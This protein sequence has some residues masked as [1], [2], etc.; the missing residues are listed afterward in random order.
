MKL[1]VWARRQSR[2]A[3]V[4]AVYQWQ[5]SDSEASS[6]EADFVDSGSLEK[7]DLEFF[8]ELL[9]GV[10]SQQ[11]ELD[12]LIEPLLDRKL[13]ALDQI[14]LA[15][16]RLGTLELKNRID[17]PY[18]VVIDQYVDLAKTFGAEEGHKY[19]NG[20]LDKLAGILRPLETT[21]ERV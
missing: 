1:N 21:S 4:Q 16:L 10:I 2:R 5:M 9:R 20:V 11:A 8:Q 18:R 3:L 19:I 15:L 12:A 17:V 7:A 13:S 14:E 6:I